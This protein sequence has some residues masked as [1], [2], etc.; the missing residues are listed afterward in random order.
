MSVNNIALVAVGTLA[1]GLVV[2]ILLYRLA[3]MRRAPDYA[4]PPPDMSA[5]K[6]VTL[7]PTADEALRDL[8]REARGGK[9]E[10]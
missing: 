10:S 4:E 7:K 1:L 6:G 8:E 2:G 5:L 3:S 9:L